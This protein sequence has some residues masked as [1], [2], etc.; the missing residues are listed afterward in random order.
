MYGYTGKILHVDLN[1][2][3]NR[4]EP[5]DEQMVLQFIGG[6]GLGVYLLWRE[7]GPTVDPLSDENKC[8][9]VTAPLTGTSSPTS[10]RA[11]VL[12]KS[13]LTGIYLYS[14]AGTWLGPALKRA[15]YDAV[16]IGGRAPGLS[17]LY[18]NGSDV[19]VRPNS[20]IQGMS[21][22]A[23][24]ENLKPLLPE[25]TALAAIGPAGEKL[26][27]FAALISD[28]HRRFGR[29]GI[30]AVL[31]SKNLK[32]I[33]VHGEDPVSVADPEGFQQWLKKIRELMKERGGPR[34]GFATY[35][36]GDAP[37]LLSGLGILPTRNWQKGTFEGADNISMMSMKDKLQ[38]VVK[39]SGCRTCPLQCG[40]ETI[41]KD[42]PYAGITTHGPEYE[43]MYAL[44][45]SCA[46]AKP[47][48]I[49]AANALCDDLGLDTMS[50]GIV[51]SFA[52]ECFERGLLTA[53]DNDN[54]E[55]HFGDDEAAYSML[56]KIADRDGL[57]DLLAEGSRA[58]AAHI[59]GGSKAFAMHVKGLELGGYDPRG[60]TSQ[61]IT[62][63]AGSRGGCHHAI[64]LGARADAV[65]PTRYEYEG[66]AEL[67]KN[68]G[69][70]QI[71]LDSM[72]GC[73]FGISRIFDFDLIAE[74]LTLLT[75]QQFDKQ[76]LIN[77]A[78]RI[79]TLE[80]MF[81]IREGVTSKEDTIPE[82][83]LKE[84]L[85]DGPSQGRLLAPEQLKAMLSE[86]Y[87]LQ[88]WDETTGTPDTS[89]LNELG[90]T[91]IIANDF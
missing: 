36:T 43:T 74:G 65:K 28:D 27:K 46:I 72:P 79:L 24:F 73:S 51:L 83:L 77:T 53:G 88:G 44:G 70:K 48:F 23:T 52:M 57:G 19:A 67:I 80:R 78:D 64:G 13:P 56:K 50:A 84:P 81:N 54:Q 38:M 68:L 90:L 71:I 20:E 1:T 58:A 17:Y 31:G 37:P 9:I 45:T 15:G 26:V 86:Y 75:G 40:S 12:T 76:V 62:F 69:R 5:L 8:I 89:R 11:L 66:K 60:A 18:I 42:G 16:I 39:D 3:R 61:A 10:S 4:I 25:K 29:G 82:R 6:R 7:V 2:G 30:G 47:D 55:L 22:R 59:G 49:I 63:A 91:K 33:A 85:S 14:M 34:D 21:P 32:A 41:V 87:H 35:G